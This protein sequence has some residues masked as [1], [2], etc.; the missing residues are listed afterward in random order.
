MCPFC[1]IGKR[2]FDKALEAFAKRDKIDVEWKSFELMPDLRSGEA[3]D[4]REML[5]ETKG[6]DMQQVKAMTSQIAQAGAQVGIDFK[7]E[8]ALAASTHR[9]HGLI[10]LAKAAGKQHQAEESLFRAL[11]TEGKN[12]DDIPT[13][14]ALGEGLGLD[15]QEVKNALE[16][17]TYDPAVER[18]IYE[19]RQ[20]G[21]RGVP[22]FVLN[23]KYAVS[24]AQEAET[25]LQALE[26][27]FDEWE[28]EQ[29]A[30]TLEVIEGKSCSPDG[31]CD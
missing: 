3:Q 1:Y 23:R 19:A 4:M 6:M 20:L 17:G 11:F 10:H 27:S 28:K 9:A 26:K 7:F 31:N 14:I 29:T 8:K 13:L 30:P 22:F 21:V 16:E 5:V 2:K 15:A 18:D 12:V 24:G 25:F